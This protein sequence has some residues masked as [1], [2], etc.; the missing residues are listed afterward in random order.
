MR[1]KAAT[2]QIDVVFRECQADEQVRRLPPLELHEFLQPFA[3]EET[4]VLHGQ[5]HPD[6]SLH[7]RRNLRANTV[8]FV[9]TRG[10]LQAAEQVEVLQHALTVSLPFDEHE[11]VLVRIQA[12]RLYRELFRQNVILHVGHHNVIEPVIDGT[13]GSGLGAGPIPH[14]GT[15]PA[16]AGPI[17]EAQRGEKFVADLLQVEIR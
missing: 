16:D 7:A 9:L 13:P 11:I 4:A 1:G 8:E 17:D 6:R 14:P 12:D 5:H 2:R 15:E 3:T 10:H